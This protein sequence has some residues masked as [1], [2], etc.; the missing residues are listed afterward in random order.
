MTSI[1][2][3]TARMRVDERL[4]TAERRR[5]VSQARAEARAEHPRHV[6]LSKAL[7]GTTHTLARV[8]PWKHSAGAAVQPRIVPQS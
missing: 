2:Y 7:H 3:G 5:M 1:D 4:R 8:A 6:L